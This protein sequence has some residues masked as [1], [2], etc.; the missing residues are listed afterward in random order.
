VKPRSDKRT[1]MKPMMLEQRR[2][3]GDRCNGQCEFEVAYPNET[4]GETHI[5]GLGAPERIVERLPDG[6]A[7][8]RCSATQGLVL[9]HIWRRHKL[10]TVLTPDGMPL[11]LHPDVVVA[12]CPSCH[13]NFDSRQ[14]RDEVRVPKAFVERGK[15]L[16]SAT[17][18]AALARGEVAVESNL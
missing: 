13:A 16:V 2:L 18:E 4:P 7:W 3:V 5:R 17:I 12:G 6:T 1:A 8:A 11:L 15:I 9:A 14:H 10:G